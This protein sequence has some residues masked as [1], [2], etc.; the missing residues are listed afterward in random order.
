M[1]VR[2]SAVLLVIAVL[3]SLLLGEEP[4]NSTGQSPPRQGGTPA[5]D[6]AAGSNADSG[7]ESNDVERIEETTRPRRRPVAP[8]NPVLKSIDG[9]SPRVLLITTDDCSK[10]DET[11]E[12]LK[13]ED[14]TF[15]R[16]KAQGWK[17]G[18]ERD[19]H[20]QIV[21]QK[22]IASFV[23]QLNV[24]RYPTVACIHEGRIVRSFK[25]GCTTPLDEWTFGW[26]YT[27]RD[28]RDEPALPQD[29]TVFWTGTYPLR[30]KHWSIEGDWVPSFEKLVIHMRGDNHKDQ[31][32]ASW[33][34]ETWSYE[35]VRSLH[36]D[37]HETGMARTPLKPGYEP[38][39]EPKEK[40]ET[41]DPPSAEAT[42]SDVASEPK[43]ETTS[44]PPKQTRPVVTP[45][46][47]VVT[48]P[49]RSTTTSR[50]APYGDRVFRKPER[51]R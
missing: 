3:A 48:Q 23:K 11:L 30:G 17:I 9:R 41:F 24:R 16:L 25:D 44:S 47:P 26:L 1:I 7:D 32:P 6:A 38:P 29:V 12:K 14:G 33:P 22:S 5:A 49:A 43:R 46:H 36:D 21:N 27:G 50:R 51:R 10:C 20:L 19:C 15:E 45:A 37:V 40:P 8:P 13:A 18:E 2:P 35:E 28:E 34:I 31:V 4:Q 42:A 39:P